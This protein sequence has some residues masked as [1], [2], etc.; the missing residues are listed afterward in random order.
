[1]QKMRY[2]ENSQYFVIITTFLFTFK[3]SIKLH[4]ALIETNYRWVLKWAKSS[5]NF[6][7]LRYQERV[8]FLIIVFYY[9]KFVQNPNL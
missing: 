2:I 6:R 5:L 9:I 1:M 7:K 4:K 8:P 3:T